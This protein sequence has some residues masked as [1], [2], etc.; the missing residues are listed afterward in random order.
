M[1]NFKETK[2]YKVLESS[3][4]CLRFPFLYP[5]NRFDGKHHN[6]MLQHILWK[7]SQ[8]AITTISITTKIQNI[9]VDTYRHSY[10]AFLN[11]Q[12]ILKKDEGLLVI[13]NYVDR[14]EIE[15]KDFINL[16]KFSVIGVDVV[17]STLGTPIEKNKG[18]TTVPKT[19]RSKPHLYN[20]AIR[21]PS[22]KK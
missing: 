20:P 11:N 2:L 21:A 17:F 1:K 14:K 10:F 8:K 19:A 13:Q 9:N 15:L 22:K 16:E 3:L 6:Y 5:R 7:L 18:G 12:V 4:L